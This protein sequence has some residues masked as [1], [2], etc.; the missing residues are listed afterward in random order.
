MNSK[1]GRK[2]ILIID[3]DE[4]LRQMLRTLF[5][6]NGCAV[7]AAASGMEGVL[8]S[9]RQLPDLIICDIRMSGI[10]GIETCRQ[11]RRRLTT[12]QSKFI[13]ILML[14]GRKTRLD[15]RAAI[16]AG[17]IDYLVKPFD[18]MKLREKVKTYIQPMEAVKQTM[19]IDELKRAWSNRR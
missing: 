16:E 6:S 10:D 13:P 17:A 15:V 7:E 19:A 2:I 3:D 8:K 9:I 5:E 4:P 1:K 12:D 11:I 14:T 18:P